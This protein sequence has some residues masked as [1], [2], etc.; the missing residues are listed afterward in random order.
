MCLDIYSLRKHINELFAIAILEVVNCQVK[1]GPAFFPYLVK[2]AK[3]ILAR[4]Y[5]IIHIKSH[6]YQQVCLF[7]FMRSKIIQIHLI[8]K[9]INQQRLS[10]DKH[11]HKN[12]IQAIIYQWKAQK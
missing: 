11:V 7:L 10:R 4:I 3:R 1:L 6:N 5:I 2:S 12:K 9:Q 8:I